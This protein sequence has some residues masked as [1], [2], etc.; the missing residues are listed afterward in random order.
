MYVVH[1]GI[2]APQWPSYIYIC[3][4]VR[5]EYTIHFILVIFLM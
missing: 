4:C 3:V 5:I 1:V 2:Y